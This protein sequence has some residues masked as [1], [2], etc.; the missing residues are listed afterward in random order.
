MLLVNGI[1]NLIAARATLK[2]K[3]YAPAFIMLQGILLGGWI[4]IQVIMV[5]QIQF[6]HI[7]M[8]LIGF[9]LLVCGFVLRQM[10]S[11]EELAC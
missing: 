10:N 8:F 3:K 6:L 2:N 4:V 7:I 1:L 9:V 5:Q 11:K